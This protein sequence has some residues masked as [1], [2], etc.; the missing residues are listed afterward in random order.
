MTDFSKILTTAAI[1]AL[2][3]A[4]TSCADMHDDLEEC[5]Y[6]LYVRFAYD[7]N[8][9]RANLFHDH[10]GHVRLYVYDEN[11]NKVAQRDL[12]DSD[13]DNPLSDHGFVLY[14]PNEELPAGHSYRLQA[15]AMQK[16]WDDALATDGAKY[17]RNDP[18]APQDLSV[19]LDHAIPGN[20]LGCKHHVVS[21]SA[22][23]DTL[24]HTLKVTATPPLETRED[25][26]TVPTLPP[27]S[28]Y[29]IESQ[30]VKVDKERY[31]YA[32]VSLIRD[33]KHLNITLRQSDEPAAVNDE[34]YEVTIIDDN[35][36]LDGNNEIVPARTVHY[37]PYHA[38][39]TRFNTDGSVEI[40]STSPSPTP[41]A[42]CT[43]QPAQ[44]SAAT[45]AATK[46]TRDADDEPLQRTA[47]YN[48]MFNR[49]MMPDNNSDG[50]RL[51]I[52]NR[53]TGASIAEISL[54]KILAEGRMAY[55]IYNYGAQEYLDREHDYHLDFILQGEKW[56]ALNINVLSWSKRI[57]NVELK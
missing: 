13:T 10:V 41:S 6:G 17:R 22:P 45:A 23:L 43:P 19:S 12:S 27:Y 31:T 56:I 48:I 47:H 49:I 46:S 4:T 26:G 2:L 50:A 36:L 38:W 1:P 25:P 11:G 5:P 39:T 15:V 53:A 28:I 34:D 8:T 40:E 51:L 14:F 57:E 42:S 33:T 9:I 24:W 29:P 3:L 18:S 37:S 35:T 32:T 30:M 20:V 54:P 55:E 16:N 44:S 7:Y 21:A 52:T